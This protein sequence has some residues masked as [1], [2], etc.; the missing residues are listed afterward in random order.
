MMIL[1]LVLAIM[2]GMTGSALAETISLDD[3][4]EGAAHCKTAILY[5]ATTD[6]VL[7]EKDADVQGPPASMTKIM[8][9]ILVLEQ[10]PELEGEF[11]VNPDAVNRYYCSYMDANPLI[12]GEVVSYQNCMEYMMLP[13]AN[14]AATAF[15]FELGDGDIHKFID[16]MNEKAKELGCENTYFKD[17]SGLSA[18]MTTPRDMV[19]IAQYAMTFDK[20]REVVAKEKGCLPVSN[21]RTEPLEFE[22]LNRLRFPDDRYENPYSQYIIG[23]KTGYTPA[24]GWCFTCCMEKD[25]LV[26]YSV[27]M[28]GEL[29]DYVDG[30]RVIQGDFIDTVNLLRMT[31]G[32]TADDLK[33]MHEP[34]IPMVVV[35][36]VSGI[37]VAVVLFLVLRTKARSNAKKYAEAEAKKK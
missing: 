36:V 10:N 35:A 15:A 8:T 3:T 6:T 16:M 31:D 11:T 19:K 28:G 20:F 29:Q 22:T 24:A 26:Y 12:A 1:T 4:W 18:H 17:P 21:K 5:E 32:L 27:V 14:E 33:A 2:G 7:Y 34:E 37:I 9:A 13:S 25:G 30:E 23:V